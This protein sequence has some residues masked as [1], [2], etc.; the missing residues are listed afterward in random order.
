MI[1]Y[2]IRQILLAIPVLFIVSLV[3]MLIPELISDD[4][5]LALSGTQYLP[6]YQYEYLS[7]HWGYDQSFLT[8][9]VIYVSHLFDLNHE[10]LSTDLALLGES[11]STFSVF[12]EKLPATFELV[13]LS[14]GIA[15]ILGISLGTL[16]AINHHKIGERIIST[17]A[18]IGYSLPT[19]WLGLLLIAY[20]SVELRIMPVAQQLSVL[21]EIP[22][23]T[24]FMLIDTLLYD[25]EAYGHGR[26]DA[27]FDAARHLALPI[28]TLC[29]L[30]LAI[31]VRMTHVSMTEVLHAGFIRTAK[32][33]GL[34]PSRVLWQ[35][36]FSSALIQ[37]IPRVGSQ[38]SVFM[39]IAIITES[40]FHWPG[41]GTWLIEAYKSGNLI[42]LR[43]GLFF[44]SFLMVLINMMVTILYGLIDPSIRTN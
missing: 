32:A 23:I 2:I 1:A 43:E 40:I 29:A 44:V 12:L 14:L 33:C 18:L 22:K 10:A 41:V 26:F 31:I 34:S 7:E 35:H 42:A 27:F 16:S 17:V 36:A 5:V 30:P 19:F 24:G 8:R 11:K 28:T 4:P 21:F 9:Y 37:F 39:T 25:H 3:T 6:P 13:L 38:A 15:L 20:F